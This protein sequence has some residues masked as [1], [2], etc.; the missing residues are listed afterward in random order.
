[1]T[2]QEI[3][4]P[5]PPSEVLLSDEA[6]VLGMDIHRNYL[7]LLA[8]RDHR[9]EPLVTLFERRMNNGLQDYHDLMRVIGGPAL[10]ASG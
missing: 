2:N 5:K 8:A 3:S 9:E 4:R 6:L 7:Q 1:M 10:R